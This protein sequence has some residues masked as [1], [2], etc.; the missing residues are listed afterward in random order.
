M[1]LKYILL[2]T[3]LIVLILLILWIW[4]HP[5]MGSHPRDTH[6]KSF[7]QSPQFNSNSKLFDNRIPGLQ[8]VMLSRFGWR[9]YLEILKPG[10]ARTPSVLLP[11]HPLDLKTFLEPSDHTKVVWLGHSSLLLNFHGK[12]ILIDP[13]LSESASPLPFIIPRFQA[14]PISIQELPSI[15]YVVISH[16]HYDHLD[17]KVAQHFARTE[18]QYIVPL[19]VGLHLQGWGVHENKITELDWWEKTRFGGIEFIATPAQHFSG[20]TLGT[21]NETLWASW[22][23]DDGRQRIYFSGDSGYDV[24]FKEI[25]DKY[26][27]FDLAFIENG[28]YNPK[29]K[30]VHLLPNETIQAFEDL[31]ARALFP[32]HWGM[33]KLA[34]HPWY[35]PIVRTY[36]AAQE[37]GIQLISPV[38]G[39]VAEIGNKASYG[40]WWEELVLKEKASQ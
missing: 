3:G 16:D 27:P 1:L 12:I 7:A 13:V 38:L 22:I 19:G 8:K 31:N 24:H 14:P 21:S 36:S 4:A 32:I 30:E 40:N 28:Q 11:E 37:R 25:G 34:W 29:W 23:L 35:E 15:D 20:R 26:G 2:L 17:M 33:F 18:T 6:L 5:A 39:Q 9:D 10:I